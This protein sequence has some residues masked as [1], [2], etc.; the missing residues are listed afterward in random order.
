MFTVDVDDP[1]HIEAVAAL[2]VNAGGVL[3]VAVTALLAD[4]Q[5]FDNDQL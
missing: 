3:T 4:G 1:A 2:R 5:P